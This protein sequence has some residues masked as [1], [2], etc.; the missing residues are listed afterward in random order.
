MLGW[1][2]FICNVL[3]AIWFAREAVRCRKAEK[4]MRDFLN[5]HT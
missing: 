2:G 5:Q 4:Q 1:G 3:T